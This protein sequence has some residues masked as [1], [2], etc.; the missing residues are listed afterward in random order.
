MLS[1]PAGDKDTCQN[2]GGVHCCW[3]ASSSRSSLEIHE[4]F[5]SALSKQS[6][7]SSLLFG[8]V[9]RGKDRGGRRFGDE[10][11]I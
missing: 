8:F 1:P 6:L 3:E 2:A 7:S 4:D 9:A 11:R 5:L 10:S